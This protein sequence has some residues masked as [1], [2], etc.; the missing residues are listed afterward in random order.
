VSPPISSSLVRGLLL[1]V[2]LVPCASAC[3]ARPAPAQTPAKKAL[4]ASPAPPAPVDGDAELASLFAAADRKRWVLC[5][6]FRATGCEGGPIAEPELV[7]RALAAKVEF[8]AL[9]TIPSPG[10]ELT[11]VEAYSTLEEEPWDSACS[12]IGLLTVSEPKRLVA[13][14]AF[15]AGGYTSEE[16]DAARVYALSSTITL[17]ASDTHAEGG[18]GRGMSSARTLYR[19]DRGQFEEVF[20]WTWE[21]SYGDESG[22]SAPLIYMIPAHA[23]GPDGA[24]D[25]MVSQLCPGSDG[26]RPKTTKQRW[27]WDGSRFSHVPRRETHLEK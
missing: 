23:Q 13:R 2:L 7:A 24:R 10:G 8:K 14:R 22:C 5:T 21:D 17:L 1:G 25:L 18:S 19:V 3:E 4:V 16:F 12:E 27:Q 26:K 6:L 11:V 9:R 20:T 15:C